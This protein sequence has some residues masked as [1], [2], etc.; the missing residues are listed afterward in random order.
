MK[1]SLMALTVGILMLSTVPVFAEMTNAQKDECLLASHNC[2]DQVDDIYSQMHKLDKEI[3]K[4][5]TTYTPDEL[6]ILN[7]KLKEVQD[8]LRVMME[9]N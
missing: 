4:G 2:T 5:T 1:K 8:T 7:A 3:T 9:H 6:R